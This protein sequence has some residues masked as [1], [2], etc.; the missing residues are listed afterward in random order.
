[1]LSEKIK[2][3]LIAD[4]GLKCEK[5][6]RLSPFAEKK[7]IESITGKKLSVSKKKDYRISCDNPLISRKRIKTIEDVDRGLSEIH[8]NW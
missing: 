6:I 4:S 8:W 7:I 5:C 3:R 1:M 2:E